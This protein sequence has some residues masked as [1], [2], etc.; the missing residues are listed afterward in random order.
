MDDLRKLVDSLPHKP[1]GFDPALLIN[2]YAMLSGQPRLGE[3]YRSEE[4]R[5]GKECA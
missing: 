4:R 3:V 1:L 2:T 5:V